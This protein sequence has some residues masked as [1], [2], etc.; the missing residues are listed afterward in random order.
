M[1]W[2]KILSISDKRIVYL[3]IFS[4]VFAVTRLA[5]I[6][7]DVINPD[8][9]NWHFRSQ[10]FIVGLKQ[11]EFE[12]TYQHY[13]PGVTLMWITGVPIELL[14]QIT[15]IQHYNN[16]NFIYFHFIAKFSLILFQLVL[17]LV[18]I[19]FLSRATDFQRAFLV[20]SLLSLEPFFLGNS[21]LYH[22]DILFTLVSFLGIILLYL[23]VHRNSF[24]YSVATGFVF[25]LSFLTR[26]IGVGLVLYTLGYFF[27][28]YVSKSADF[29]LKK[30]LV[31]LSAF[32]VSSFILFPALWVRPVHYISE[33]FSEG[34]RIGV[35][36]GHSQLFFG[37]QTDDAGV[38]FYPLVLVMK[39]SPVMLFG[40]ICCLISSCRKFNIYNLSFKF[41][42][43][44]SFLFVITSFYFGY[45]AIMSV[46][47]KK[48]DR[49]MLFMFPLL[50]YCA[51]VGLERFY[52]YIH[53][54]FGISLK[55]YYVFF[56]TFFAATLFS[57]YPYYFTYTSPV[58]LNA[59]TANSV[60]GQK[61]FGVGIFE[62]KDFVNENYKDG[63]NLGFIDTKPMKAVYANSGVF[64]IRV[65]DPGDYDLI[66]LGINEEF[67]DKVLKSS[68]R[69]EL[70]S[71][72]TI[73]GL[74]YWRIYDK[75]TN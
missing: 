54:R 73:N 35:R 5:G 52:S 31:I 18:L 66:I 12:K 59:K 7:T 32:V 53:K 23:S 67:P 50:G 61:P 63:V 58:F 3:V 55:V 11:L 26:S 8:A 38:L 29:S 33:I 43:K 28:M 70:S 46:L 30:L 36:K 41:I 45:F 9:V 22:M 2:V 24:L 51:V 69:F 40:I 42:G 13:H 15:G 19:Y 62:L 48:I 49:Y 47:S 14:K 16:T 34:Q 64:D 21:R 39:M 6:K 71:V 1:R 57:F 68:Q 17:S 10:Q 75:K 27:I 37:K 44:N 25:S 65:N 20:M 4:V 72:I 60:I 56:M 74:E